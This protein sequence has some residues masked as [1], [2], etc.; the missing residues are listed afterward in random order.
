MITCLPACTICVDWK[1]NVSCCKDINTLMGRKIV[2]YVDNSAANNPAV[3]QQN[4][5]YGNTVQA[6]PI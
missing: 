6:K 2:T 3:Q 1:C 4:P 5:A